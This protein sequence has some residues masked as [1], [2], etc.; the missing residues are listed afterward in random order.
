MKRVYVALVLLLAV[1]VGCI[2]SIILETRQFKSMIDTTNE[3]ERCCLADDIARA[4]QLAKGLQQKF[5]TKSDIYALF[6]H[7]NMLLEIEESLVVIPYHLRCGEIDHVL[8]EIA[9]CR[10]YLET[11]METEMPTW[12]NIF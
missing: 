4:T 12:D 9:R 1:T 6:L 3:I 7:H 11:Q 2:V 8:S 10:L 5:A